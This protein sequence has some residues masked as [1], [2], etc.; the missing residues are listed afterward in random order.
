MTTYAK[1]TQF[2]LS[3]WLQTIG[4][5]FVIAA[6]MPLVVGLIFKEE[7]YLMVMLAMGCVGGSLG[8][9]SFLVALVLPCKVC[10]KKVFII[11]NSSKSPYT[12]RPKN[13]IE[14]AIHD[15]YPIEIREHKFRCVHCGEEYHLT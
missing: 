5:Y 13:Q 6:L 7:L 10:H 2:K 4:R 11:F 15:F 3:V 1:S 8:L 9:A 14:A 12:Y